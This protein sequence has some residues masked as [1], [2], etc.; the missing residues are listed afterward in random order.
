M[1]SFK[2]LPKVSSINVFLVHNLP[3]RL[4]DTSQGDDEVG[5]ADNIPLTDNIQENHDVGL[6]NRGFENDVDENTQLW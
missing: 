4:Q 2:N 3:C 1:F 5:T 6:L